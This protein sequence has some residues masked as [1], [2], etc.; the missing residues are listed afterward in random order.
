MHF[1]ATFRKASDAG[2]LERHLVAV[3][4][5]VGAV[6]AFG[7][8]VHHRIARHDPALGRLLNAASTAG[9]YLL[10]MTPPTMLSTNS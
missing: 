9:M 1:G 3:H 7:L 10:G 8:E 2:H 5:V 4:I 6:E